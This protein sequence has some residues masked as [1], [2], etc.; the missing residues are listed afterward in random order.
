MYLLLKK[1][2]FPASHVSLLEGK[3]IIVAR[4][5]IDRIPHANPSLGWTRPFLGMASLA[6]LRVTGDLL[7]G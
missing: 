7:K 5:G 6:I 4:F 1:G 3:G 2:D